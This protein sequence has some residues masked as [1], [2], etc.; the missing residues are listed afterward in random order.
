MLINCEFGENQLNEHR[1][2]LWGV[3]KFISLHCTFILRFDWNFVYC[4]DT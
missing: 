1:A 2:F 3:D 4:I